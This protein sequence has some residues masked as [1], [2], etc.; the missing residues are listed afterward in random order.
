MQAK[1]PV[2]I[3]ARTMRLVTAYCPKTF[4]NI[5]TLLETLGGHGSGRLPAGILISPALLQSSQ[6]TIC[7]PMVMSAHKLYIYLQKQSW[8]V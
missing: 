5:A 6:N 2:Q 3:P 7:V 1:H 8:V 4:P